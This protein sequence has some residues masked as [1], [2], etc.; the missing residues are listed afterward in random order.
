M[1]IIQD[2]L[3]LPLTPMEPDHREKL[4]ALM[5]RQGLKV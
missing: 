4:L 3:R 2:K 5:R 1:G